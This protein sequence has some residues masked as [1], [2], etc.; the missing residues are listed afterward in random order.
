[1]ELKEQE[2]KVVEEVVKEEEITELEP[3][4]LMNVGGGRMVVHF[5]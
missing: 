4:L 1:M 5:G 2:K 3:S